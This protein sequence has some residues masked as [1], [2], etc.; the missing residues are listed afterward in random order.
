MPFVH[1]VALNATI[2]GARKCAQQQKL[3]WKAISMC[4]Q[5]P[6]GNKLTH[7]AGLA[8]P[9]HTFIPW[10]VV[11]NDSSSQPFFRGHLKKAICD[12][13]QGQERSGCDVQ[14]QHSLARFFAQFW[15]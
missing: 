6:L 4:S 7:E 13:Y 5:G 2:E 10:I 14:Q 11:N 8:T 9:P 3:D 1:C 12:S 15:H